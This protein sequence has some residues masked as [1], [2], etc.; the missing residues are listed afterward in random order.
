MP[1]HGGSLCLATATWRPP[2]VAKGARLNNYAV[3]AYNYSSGVYEQLALTSETEL[4]LQPWT[5]SSLLNSAINLR[6]SARGEWFNPKK[7][8]WEGVIGCYATT[9][10]FYRVTWGSGLVT[11]TDETPDERM[12]KCIDDSGKMFIEVETFDDVVRRFLVIIDVADIRSRSWMRRPEPR[13]PP[14][15]AIG[16]IGVVAL[17]RGWVIGS[18]DEAV[19]VKRTRCANTGGTSNR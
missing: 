1:D 2:R 7:R 4:V 17:A 15:L 13:I 11:F 12:R 9:P 18:D 16:A 8:E 19:E 3:E 14:A 10:S 5:E 6:V